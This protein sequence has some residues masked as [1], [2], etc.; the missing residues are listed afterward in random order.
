MIFSIVCK[1]QFEQNCKGYLRRAADANTVTLAKQ[2]LDRALSY[3]ES[4]Q[5]T[6][7]STHTLYSTPECDIEFWYTNLKSGFNEL[8]SIPS[9]A[10]KLTTSTQLLKLH[11][12]I[13]NCGEHERVTVPANIYVYPFQSPILWSTFSGLAGLAIGGLILYPPT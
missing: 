5:L 11:E 1:I 4:K 13:V 6:T 2:E 3:L 8:D 7:G 9:G 12:T 10:D